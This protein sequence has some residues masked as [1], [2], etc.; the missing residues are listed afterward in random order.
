MR[1]LAASCWPLFG[2]SSRNMLTG[3]LF[4]VQDAQLQ[5][6]QAA[7]AEARLGILATPAFVPLAFG[8]AQR[9]AAEARAGEWCIRRFA[10]PC[11]RVPLGRF[12]VSLFGTC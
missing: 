5:A 7:L 4:R 3:S 9:K 10:G 12:S 1:R 6:E 11:L 2:V 8:E